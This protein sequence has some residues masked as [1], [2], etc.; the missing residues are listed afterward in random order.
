MR[1]KPDMRN[2]QLPGV[3]AAND[4]TQVTITDKSVFLCN[5]SK[6]ADYST[7]SKDTIKVPTQDKIGICANNKS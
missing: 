6:Q 3:F 5:N 7:N 4:G 2:Y 1:V